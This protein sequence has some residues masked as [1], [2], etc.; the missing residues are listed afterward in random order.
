MHLFSNNKLSNPLE[1]SNIQTYASQRELT[2]NEKSHLQMT[3]KTC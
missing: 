1:Y 2:K 3:G